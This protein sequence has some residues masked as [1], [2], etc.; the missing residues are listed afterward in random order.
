MT[1]VSGGLITDLGNVI[2]A[3]WLSN[4]T[5]ENFYTIDY[6]AIPEV[7]DAFGIL[8]HFNE[9]FEGN[10]TVA[11]KATGVAREK[12]DAWLD[13]H[14]FSARTGISTNRIV[15]SPGGRDKTF[16]LNQTSDTYCGTTIVVDDRLE[17]LSHF[18]G[19]VPHLFLFRPQLEEVDQ[20]RSTGALAHVI[21]VQSWKEIEKKMG[22]T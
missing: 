18:V 9:V 22:I 5:P 20:F 8:K 6:N 16:C 7:P 4:I 19:K 21:M 13:Y 11:Y 14:R 15:H 12:I 1:T 2:I 10:V 3:Y 17:V